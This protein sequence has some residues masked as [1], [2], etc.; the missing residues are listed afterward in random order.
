MGSADQV[1]VVL[2]EEPRNYVWAKGERYTSVV[3]APSGNV[4]VG[5]GPEEIAEQP[6]VGDLAEEGWLAIR[7]VFSTA[8]EKA[9][10]VGAGHDLRQ[11]AA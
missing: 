11:W 8:Q 2:L 1:H 9:A 10:C 7:S 5:I 6:A 4:L 3:F